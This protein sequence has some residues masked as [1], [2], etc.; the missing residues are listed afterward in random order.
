MTAE[1]EYEAI[2]WKN[3]IVGYDQVDPRSLLANEDNWRMHPLYQREVVGTALEDIGWIQDIVVNKRTH[4]DWS[5]KERG[6]E[7]VLDGHLRVLLALQTDQPLV[8]IKYVDL[9]PEEEKMAL[10]ILDPSSSLATADKT[11]LKSLLEQAKPMS[12]ATKQLLI[13]LA[14]KH[15]IKFDEEDILTSED[16]FGEFSEYG[17][18]DESNFVD[19]KFGDYSAKIHQ[20]TY[21][22]FVAKINQIKEETGEVMID[23][24]L[25]TL[26]QF[27]PVTPLEQQ[28]MLGDMT[29]QGYGENTY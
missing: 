24:V 17:A 23:N 19:F 28:S 12:E 22:T 4:E 25:Q 29:K 18:D 20:S 10:L 15:K 14:D 26:L 5:D 21:D 27:T 13:D 16:E 2:G 6:I 7:T 11:R 1:P 8:P 9:S 3:R